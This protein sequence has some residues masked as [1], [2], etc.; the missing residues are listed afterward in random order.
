MPEVSFLIIG[1]VVG[2][3]LLVNTVAWIVQTGQSGWDGKVLRL[4]E[5]SFEVDGNLQG[6]LTLEG[7]YVNVETDRHVAGM[8]LKFHTLAK[9]FQK[10][11][12]NLNTKHATFPHS[13]FSHSTLP[14]TLNQP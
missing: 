11:L 4:I 1:A 7:K 3:P 10:C 6:L 5:E 14:N 8:G 9:K 13:T 12:K 2:L